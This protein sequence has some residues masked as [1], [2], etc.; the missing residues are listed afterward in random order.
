[1]AGNIDTFQKT[2]NMG[3]SA[4]WDRMWEQAALFYR[5]ALKEFPDDPQGLTS[6]GLALFELQR[7]EDALACYRRAAVITPED[8][9]PAD[10]ICQICERMGR[11][12]DA[13]RAGLQAADLY[14]KNREVEK[15]IENWAR[16]T[17]FNPENM[18]AHT[19]LALVYERTN[20]KPEAV[21]EYITVA[22]L[23]QHAGDMVKASQAVAYA[24]QIQPDSVEARQALTTLKSSQMLPKPAR[25]RGGTGPM[26]MSQVRKLE[27]KEGESSEKDLLDP[28]KEARQTALVSLADV[29]FEQIDESGEA[30]AARR[31]LSSITSG[32]SSSSPTAP[33]R[34]KIIVHLSQAVEA[35]TQNQNAQ[36]ADELQRAI[37]AGLTRPAAFYDLGYLYYELGQ[38]ENVLP[39]LRV[40]V[41][42]TDYAM[43]SHLL[44]GIA[45]R[46]RGKL[47]EA[48]LEF[49]QALK[50]ADAA[51]VPPEYADSIRQLYEPL[52]DAQLRQQNEASLK[53]I[54]TNIEQQLL[55][56]DWRDYLEKARQQIPDQTIGEPPLPVAEM[57]LQSNS[58]EVVHS[59]ALIRSMS[60]RNQTRTAMEEAYFALEYAPAYL[61]LHIQMGELLLQENRTADAIQKFTTVVRAYSVRGDGVQAT[62][63]LRR[64]IQLNPMDLNLRVQLIDQLVALGKTEEAMQAYQELAE[65]Y[66]RLADLENA[67]KTYMTALRF[68]QQAPDMRSW[69]AKI[70]TAMA[71]IDMQRMDWRQALR[72]YEQIRTLQPDDEK[73]RF[74]L[75]DINFRMG[76]DGAALIETENYLTYLE[77]KGER[78]KGI[79]FVQWLINDHPEKIDLHRRL[80]DLFRQNGQKEE[81]ISALDAVGDLLITA[82]NTSGAITVIQSILEMNPTNAPD[83]RRLLSQLVNKK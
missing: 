54:C 72:V 70:L 58:V 74:N 83:Y 57:L 56:P 7:Y 30:P 23:M 51:T 41:K 35:Q 13:T 80:A 69:N 26:L 49:M 52:I 21:K 48:A 28:V 79:Q 64:I 32:A 14:M 20:R 17:R 12:N 6:L 43:A 81:A 33:E 38:W 36:A 31:G 1:M 16:V 77:S 67:R 3:H 63:L 61:P 5:Q 8:P 29:L 59:L 39:N 45:Q 44:L 11:L 27:E 66:Y 24:L 55:R 15:A 73:T 46:K 37:E 25:S 34:S 22:A 53:T 40:S 47:S 2:M 65:I 71:D 76:Q 10:K 9:L 82:G 4:A 75:V 50:I 60:Q 42:N 19:R 62:Q 68:A 18:T 78:G